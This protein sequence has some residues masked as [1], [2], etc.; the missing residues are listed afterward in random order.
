MEPNKSALNGLLF[1][2]VT[3]MCPSWDSLAIELS[4]PPNQAAQVPPDMLALAWEDQQ[5]NNSNK[6]Q[7]LNTKEIGNK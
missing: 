6:K 2:V 1:L 3:A 7:Q 4:L 5:Q